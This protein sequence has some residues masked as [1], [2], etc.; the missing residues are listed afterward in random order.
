[1]K[2]NKFLV[3]LILILV[4]TLFISTFVFAND[5]NVYDCLTD[6]GEDLCV[7][8]PNYNSILPTPEL[9]STINDNLI[10]GVYFTG[11]GCPHCAKIDPILFKETLPNNPN[12]VII[13]LEAKQ[14][15]ENAIFIV[16]YDEIYN[17]G[18]S[19][20]FLI[21][22]KENVYHYDNIIVDFLDNNFNNL[23]NNNCPLP[24]SIYPKGA[25][26]FLELNLNNLEGKPI[27][28]KG[29]RALEKTGDSAI[30]SEQL[31][32]L[33]TD[34]NI[35]S[36]LKDIPHNHLEDNYLTYSGDVIFF[37]NTAEMD[38]WKFYWNGECNIEDQNLAVCEPGTEYG[39]TDK[40]NY[41]RLSLI[42]VIGL[43]LADAVNPCAFAVLLMLLLAITTS[44]PEKKKRMLLSGLA[45]TLSIFVM[46]FL[47]GLLLVTF[48][49]SFTG[50]ISVIIYKVFAVVAILLGIWQL[51]DF[52]YYRP[53]NVGT[54]MPLGLRPKV[55]KLIS[56]A[57]SP[58][59]AMVIGIFITLFLLPCTIGPYIIAT[60]S[61]AFIDLMKSIPLLLLYNLIFVIPM[62][63]LTF[64]VYFGIKKINDLGAWKQKNIKYMHLVAGSIILLL[65]VLMLFGLL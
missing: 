38:G 44:N 54:E 15:R 18:F 65:G 46:Y 19:I 36:I 43:A 57:T 53:G 47:Y 6:E 1:M 32:L 30:T 2:N 35:D 9:Y 61:L 45:F 64:L 27:I 62:I 58:R 25:T 51:K 37:Y 34:E 10:C 7:I 42:K 21:L 8:E 17:S 29:D 28:W 5:T 24:T 63:V 41:E 52:F 11:I 4:F 40:A 33:L 26:S 16:D 60:S 23:T 48:F 31:H 50:N 20:P 39:E 14:K 3:Y 13:E 56:K 59:G 22:N 49:G 55:N 12:L